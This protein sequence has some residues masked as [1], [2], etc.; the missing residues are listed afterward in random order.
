MTSAAAPPDRI[1]HSTVREGIIAGAVGATG[2]A[3]WFLAVDLVAAHAF[4]MPERLGP[5]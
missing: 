3:L 4:Y 2:V 1:S 5:R